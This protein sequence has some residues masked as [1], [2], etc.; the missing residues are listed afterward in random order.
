MC[1]I[2]DKI[3]DHIRINKSMPMKLKNKNYQSIN[4]EK[5][6]VRYLCY[7]LESLIFI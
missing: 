7:Y 3:Y 1:V 4:P 5:P 2:L 6:R